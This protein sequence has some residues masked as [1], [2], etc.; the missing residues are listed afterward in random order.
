M[1]ASEAIAKVQMVEDSD[2]LTTMNPELTITNVKRLILDGLR[3]YDPDDDISGLY[4][5]RV[6][7]LIKNRPHHG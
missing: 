1:K 2:E 7:Q 3:R 4:E 6:W 5:K